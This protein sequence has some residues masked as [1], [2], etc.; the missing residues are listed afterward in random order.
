MRY[1]IKKPSTVLIIVYFLFIS[2]D[3]RLPDEWQAPSWKLPLT[4]PLI[5]T[6][7]SMATISSPDN[8][9]NIPCEEYF[10]DLNEN[11]VWDS[12]EEF[13]DENGDGICTPSDDFLLSID[14]T[15]IDSG[16]INIEDELFYIN[17][18]AI[19]IPPILFS[20]PSSEDLAGD[21][22]IDPVSIPFPSIGSYECIPESSVFEELGISNVLPISDETTESIQIFSDSD[23]SEIVGINSIHYLTIGSGGF[24]VNINNTFPYEIN[25]FSIIL[26]DTDADTVW[27]SI[28]FLNISGEE[29]INNN[30]ANKKLPGALSLVNSY[31]ITGES[32]NPNLSDCEEL[33]DEVLNFDLDFTNN[34]AN[35]PTYESVGF[36]FPCLCL[37]DAAYNI[38]C[39]DYLVN[40]SECEAQSPQDLSVTGLSIPSTSKF[41]WSDNNCYLSLWSGKL[42]SS[43]SELSI[44]INFSLSEFSSLTADVEISQEVEEEMPFSG[45]AGVSIIDAHI[46]D[47]GSNN[48][49]TNL[50]SMEINNGLFADI[51]FELGIN[52]FVTS[53]ENGTESFS[54]RD[55][56]SSGQSSVSIENLSDMYIMNSSGGDIESIH[57]NTNL[58]IGSE[59]A[60]LEFGKEYSLG[61]TADIKVFEL[62]KINVRL[63]EFSTP[64]L[65]VASI[66]AGFV[67]FKL[68]TLA[69]NLIFYNQIRAPLIL[70][71]EMVGITGE[72]SLK[73]AIQPQLN[74][75]ELGGIDTT[76]IAFKADT[77]KIT[78]Q[79]DQLLTDQEGN[80]ASIFDLFSYDEL[81]IQGRAILE[82]EGTLERNKGLWGDVRIDIQPLSFIFPKDM[83]IIPQNKS[84]IEQ[85]DRKTAEQIDSG[86]V[87]VELYMG[88]TNHTPLLMD[89]SMFISNNDFFPICLDSLVEGDLLNSMVSDTCE[90][91]IANY[92][93]ND[94]N[95][96]N[97]NVIL[98]NDTTVTLDSIFVAET[99]YLIDNLPDLILEEVDV[100]SCYGVDTVW[101][102]SKEQ[103][104]DLNQIN[105][106]GSF[107]GKMVSLSLDQAEN[108]DCDGN[109]LLPSNIDN[110]I[111]MGN[112][113]LKWIS[114]PTDLYLSPLITIY[115]TDNIEPSGQCSSYDSR[116]TIN[117]SDYLEILSFIR[118]VLKVDN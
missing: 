20:T 88:T 99:K 71:L 114:R 118:M 112:T 65:P 101:W 22:S 17:V 72:D 1:K 38:V 58:F 40:E 35:D 89:L 87:S 2:C 39:D 76:I 14:A 31:N 42:I 56:V 102:W 80:S 64:D 9:I 73:L 117:P 92:F 98:L 48:L 11:G 96:E 37:D 100:E 70:D 63:Q 74:L 6:K 106:L 29:A 24:G 108:I 85:L 55:T 36:L 23:F 69:F 46:M 43:S 84:V 86:L 95:L 93:N 28:S 3:I 116:I 111:F 81:K 59:F 8:M 75:P 51:I 57:I 54:L 105:S 107:Y 50:I 113:E 103:C 68:P 33:Y 4:M 15:V 115:G 21:F 82:G 7:Y 30:L 110:T 16:L 13:E 94:G 62:D 53:S 66:P 44:G 27:N 47:K 77:M 32:L 83:T 78:D 60:T 34:C 97:I 79:V 19:D 91:T 45:I 61:L 12:N 10:V 49:D 5:N 52:E 25:D 67:D 18:G 90:S 109:V 26:Y 41:I 104:L